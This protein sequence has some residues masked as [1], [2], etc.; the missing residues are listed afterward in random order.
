MKKTKKWVAE[1]MRGGKE[2]RLEE[3]RGEGRR[4]EERTGEEGRIDE[5]MYVFQKMEYSC[6]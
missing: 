5:L 3:T 4:R 1:Q 2:K 6:K